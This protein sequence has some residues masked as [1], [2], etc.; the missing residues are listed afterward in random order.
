LIFPDRAYGKGAAIQFQGQEILASPEEGLWSIAIKW[1]N[2][3]PDYWLHAQATTVVQLAD[4]NVL[5][6]KISLPQGDWIIRDMYREESG[7]IRCHRRWEWQGN[8]RLDSVTLSVR[9]QIPSAMAKPFLPGILYY[10]NPSGER[11]GRDQVAWY[12]GN[13]GE[14]AMFEE[15]RYPMPFSC[16]EW[17][18][19]GQRF[20]AALH[21]LPSPVYRGNRPDQWWSLGLKTL[22]GRTELRGL[23]GPIGYNGM[24]NAAKA[25]QT[26]SMTYGDT[27][28]QVLPKTV[29]EK[30]FFL[31]AFPVKEKGT[32]FQRPVHTAID[33]YRPFWTGD[34]PTYRETMAKKYRFALSR[35]LEGAGY[36]GFNMFPPH[37]KPQIVLGWAGQSEAPAYALQVLADEL[38]DDKVWE[39]V[40]QSLDHICSADMDEQGFCVIYDIKEKKWSGKDPVSQGQAMNSIALAIREGRK[41]K[42]VKTAQWE[43]FL[44]GAAM[45][46]SH[47]ILARDWRPVNTA[48]AFFIAPLLH[49]SSLFHDAIYRQA[50]LKA[51][52]YF[53]SRHLSMDEPYWGGTLDATCEDKEGAWGAFQGFLAAYEATGDRKYLEH[54]RHACDVTLSYTV[55]WDIPQPPGRLA[56]HAFKSRG[57]TGVSAQNQHLDVYGVLIAPS[58]YQMGVYLKD[59]H[60]MQLARTMFL[61]CGQLTDPTGSQGEQIQH[62]LFAQHGEMT[63]LL[64]LRGGYSES[65]TVFWITAHFL[66]AAAQFRELGVRW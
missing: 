44:Q 21:S 4:W 28:M 33:L 26:G 30:S 13:L 62:T 64:R 16:V 20:G 53:A 59:N 15:H 8:E 66:H 56:D 48:G 5:T 47:R 23:S 34:L 40:Q 12:H 24:K 55:L 37:R 50:A 22:K 27:Y 57:W 58:V 3:A 63:D 9:W 61:S 42:R 60:L 17:G 43:K 7:R 45:L 41:N 51:A 11:N 38:G 2:E 39:R 52:D 10:G 49:A 6:G 36:A 25:L 31:E 32:A 29:I 54:A 14:E 19:E 35:W 1:K 18:Q 46:F 65:W